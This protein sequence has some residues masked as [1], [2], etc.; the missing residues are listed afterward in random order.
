MFAAAP[1]TTKAAIEDSTQAVI[2]MHVAF[3]DKQ[4]N[5]AN[6]LAGDSAA[7]ELL[8]FYA[9]LLSAQRDIYELLCQHVGA[10]DVELLSNAMPLL[11]RSI[12]G[13]ASPQLSDE[14]QTLKT[15][16]PGYI[17]NMLL[18]YANHRLPTRF[19]AKAL[20]QPYGR[21]CWENDVKPIGAKPPAN[22]RH[23]HSCGGLAQVSI[24]VESDSADG[25]S[26]NLLCATCLYEWPYRR[27]ACASCGE[28]VPAKLAYFKAEQFAHIK[29][30]ICETCRRY[31]KSVDLTELGN[32][33]PLVDD[34]GSASLDLWAVERGYTKLEINLVGL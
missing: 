33:S 4:I 12:E 5:R 29:V 8:T 16:A 17:S 24:R 30:E 27:V 11:L 25:G 23:C 22:E 26:R 20:F 2:A 15:S 13:T 1:A 9:S 7:N 31:V 34:V 3:W 10:V 19:F 6:E 21:W 28:E 32:A 14:M 18:E